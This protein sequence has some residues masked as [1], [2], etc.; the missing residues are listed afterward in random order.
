VQDSNTPSFVQPRLE[1]LEAIERDAWLDMV[2]AAPTEFSAAVG[3][4][5]GRIGSA[6]FVALRKVPLVQFNHAHALGIDHPLSAGE[7]DDVLAALKDAASPVWAVQVPDTPHFAEARGW[8]TA[9]GLSA[10]DAWAKFWRAPIPPTEAR[11]TLSVREV[12]GDRAMDFGQVVQAGF[13]APPP[14]ASWAAALVGRPGWR[15][16]VAYDGERPVGA[17]ALYSNHG[18]G[19]LGLGSTVPS[20][21]GRGAQNALL[22]R[23]IADAI[24][25]GARALVTET[26]QPLPGEEAGHP[27]YRNILRAGFEVAYLRMNYRPA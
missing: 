2:A 10:S 8:L 3:L 14:F 7:I 18:L 24:T 4:S 19:W 1:D 25:A 26:G 27:S 16:Y 13:S 5:A 15:S 21:R 12:G 17:G 9:R 23:R 11:T 22:A 6:G 20:H